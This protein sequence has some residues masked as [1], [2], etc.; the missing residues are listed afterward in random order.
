MYLILFFL[1]FS[2]ALYSKA[3][4][5]PADGAQTQGCCCLPSYNAQERICILAISEQFSLKASTQHA[6]LTPWEPWQHSKCICKQWGNENFS[7]KEHLDKGR[8]Y[9]TFTDHCF[10]LIDGL[11]FP[12]DNWNCMLFSCLPCFFFTVLFSFLL[13]STFWN[14]CSPLGKSFQFPVL[15][16]AFFC[17]LLTICTGHFTCIP[18]LHRDKGPPVLLHMQKA[19]FVLWEN[20]VLVHYKSLSLR[21]WFTDLAFHIMSFLPLFFAF[22]GLIFFTLWSLEE[23]LHNSNIFKCLYKH[24]CSC[25]S[26]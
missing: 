21:F 9:T 13:T 15:Y 25:L 8:Y 7:S 20:T 19:V 24:S 5:H 12:S 18:R 10:L 2:S 11:P 17:S 22:S 16:S 23:L 1:F 3:T 4:P 6:L 14:G 26:H